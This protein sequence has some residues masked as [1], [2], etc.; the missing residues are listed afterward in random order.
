MVFNVMAAMAEF[1]RSMIRERAVAGIAAARGQAHGRRRSLTEEQCHT[2]LAAINDG[3]RWAD[4]ASRY[5]VHIRT[6]K[7][8]FAKV[9]GRLP[10]DAA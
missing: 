9:C 1:G 10:G 2:A 6:L 3:E 7:R 4:V 5:Q 8:G